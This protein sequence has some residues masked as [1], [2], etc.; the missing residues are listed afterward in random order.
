MHG[1]VLKIAW[2]TIRREPAAAAINLL[3]LAIGM[4]CCMLITLYIRHELSYDGFHA[5]GDRIYRVIAESGRDEQRFFQGANTS[6]PVG[7][8]LKAHFPEVA[9]MVRFREGF[10]AV[11]SYGDSHFAEKKFYMADPAVFDVFTFRFVAGNPK[12]ALAQPSNVVLTQ[13]MARKYF[14]NADPIGKRLHYEGWGGPAELIVTAVLADLPDNTHFDFD[15]LASLRLIDTSDFSWTWF[16]S[17]WTYILLPE[18][19]PVAHLQDKFPAFIEQVVK[20]NLANQ[21]TWFMLGLEPLT[22][23]HLHSGLDIQMRPVSDIRYIYLFAA[24]AVVILILACINFTNLAIARS[25]RRAREVGL[26]KALGGQRLDLMLQFLGESMLIC[27][28]ALVLGVVL[29]ELAMPYF[30]A[31]AG[32]AIQIDYLGDAFILLAL[33]VIL[34]ATGFMAGGY[35][36]WVISRFSPITALKQ[37]APTGAKSRTPLRHLLVIFQFAISIV[38]L[39]AVLAISTQLDYIRHKQLG[40]DIEQVVVIPHSE[41]AATFLQALQQQPGI[42]SASASSRVPVNTESFDTRPVFIDGIEAAVQMEN[43]NI[44]E[45]FLR[46]Y[47][48]E[49]VAGR[50]LSPNLA[51]DS[52]AFLLNESAVKAFGWG[53]PE[54]AIGKQIG[55]QFGYKKGTVIGVVKDFHM[56]SLHEEIRP[57]ILHKMAQPFWYNFIS[58]RLQPEAL[59]ITLPFIEQTWRAFNPRGGYEFF[60]V[61][62]GFAALHRADERFGQVVAIFTAMAIFIASLGLFGLVSF[63]AEQR[64]REIGIRKVLGASVASVVRLFTSDYAKLVLIANVVAWPLAWFAMQRWLQTFAYRSPELTGSNG[65]WLLAVAGLVALAIALVTVS[66]QAVKAAL[67]NPVDSLRAE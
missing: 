43:F 1:N 3:G 37:A 61:D 25:L 4:A 51:S 15:F 31:I 45:G 65:W 26:R 38:L 48:I 2:R 19:V 12:T 58:V 34:L 13:R 14:G 56:V 20:P 36:A 66:A 27:V 60:F 18:D 10:G 9:D 49:L 6:F 21:E 32:K 41:K 22:N 39:V 28:L 50:N 17:L 40:A 44:D 62:E 5:Q 33:L 7:P 55:W 53:A 47:G 46:T 64:T 35:P 30:N 67:A 23:I 63:M 24:I 52:S 8:A 16:T 42:I 29:A 54:N 59:A 11:V 57:L